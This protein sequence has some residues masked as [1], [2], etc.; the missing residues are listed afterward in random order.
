MSDAYQ[1]YLCQQRWERGKRP[2]PSGRIWRRALPPHSPFPTAHSLSWDCL[3]A[4]SL[5]WCAPLLAVC[6]LTS[7]LALGIPEGPA[8]PPY[9]ALAAPTRWFAVPVQ[10]RAQA[11]MLHTTGVCPTI[12]VLPGTPNNHP[13]L[14]CTVLL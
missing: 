9:V 7:V 8:V 6:G 13:P 4:L 12:T 3:L 2:V 11:M 10:D 5:T 14:R 1:D